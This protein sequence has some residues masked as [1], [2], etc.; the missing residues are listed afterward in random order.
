MTSIEANEA[1]IRRLQYRR[2]EGVIR[3][4]ADKVREFVTAHYEAWERAD[5]ADQLRQRTDF[6]L[7]HVRDCYERAEVA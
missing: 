3:E 4:L 6:A 7:A 1:S 2:E 5:V